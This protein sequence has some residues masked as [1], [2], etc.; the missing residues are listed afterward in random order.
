[1]PGTPKSPHTP[2]T[3]GSPRMTQVA[4]KSKSQGQSDFYWSTHM[5]P[6]VARKKALLKKYGKEINQLMT[7]EPKT[8][9]ICFGVV[10]LHLLVGGYAANQPSWFVYFLLCYVVGGSCGHFLFLAIHEVT[11]YTAFKT[12]FYNDLLAIWCNIPI[13]IPYAMHFKEYHYEHHRYM[14]WDG[15]DTDL[16]TRIEGQLLSSFWGKLFFLQG[17]IFFYAMRPM[18]VRPLKYNGPRLMNL[19]FILSTDALLAYVF[20]WR[21]LF[22]YLLSL[23]F[24][25]GINPFSG[26]FLSEHYLIDAKSRKDHPNPEAYETRSHYGPL[27]LLA[28]NVGYHNEHHDFPNIPWSNLPKL[29][30]LAPE[31]YDHLPQTESWFGAQ[32]KFLFDKDVGPWCRVL[33]EEGA[34]SKSGQLMPTTEDSNGQAESSI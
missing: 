27:N 7:T 1:M 23:F 5:E 33:R 30:A 21:V 26:H 10:L 25:A 4:A 2:R 16:P 32:I 11:H 18:L 31:F 12:K 17:Q 20:G 3:N 6:H 29:R 9:W 22:Y 8:K 15:V 24:A 28:W 14:G 13:C 19:L 34:G